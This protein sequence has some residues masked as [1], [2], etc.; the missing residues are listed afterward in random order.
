MKGRATKMLEI[1]TGKNCL[2]ETK[3]ELKMFQKFQ[4][5]LKSPEMV[6]PQGKGGIQMGKKAEVKTKVK[7]GRKGG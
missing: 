5:K 3:G 7:L 4:L 6:A 2:R 1:Y